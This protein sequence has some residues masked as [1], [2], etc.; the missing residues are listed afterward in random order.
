MEYFEKFEGYKLSKGPIQYCDNII[1][2]EN[3][4]EFEITSPRNITG[5]FPVINV[6]QEKKI[7][8]GSKN[9]YRIKINLAPNGSCESL[10]INILTPW[11]ETALDYRIISRIA[12]DLV[13]INENCVLQIPSD[14]DRWIEN[15]ESALMFILDACKNGEKFKYTCSIPIF[16]LY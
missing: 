3:D 4:Y 8:R 11:R 16:N 10:N 14:A 9:L 6:V 5:E 15:N 13:H 2:Y 7:C 12:I 1:C